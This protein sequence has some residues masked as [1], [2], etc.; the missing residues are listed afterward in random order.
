MANHFGQG[1]KVPSIQCYKTFDTK[2]Y[3]ITPILS[4]IPQRGYKSRKV[5]LTVHEQLLKHRKGH[6]PI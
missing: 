4:V 1:M 6:V 5:R 2:H 3:T